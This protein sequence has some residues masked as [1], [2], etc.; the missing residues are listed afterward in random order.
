[1]LTLIIYIKCNKASSNQLDVY[2]NNSIKSENL[3]KK[4]S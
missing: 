1:M 3:Y 4:Y 2:G